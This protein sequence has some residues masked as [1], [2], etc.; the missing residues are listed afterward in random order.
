MKI[1]KRRIRASKW[2]EIGFKLFGSDTKKW[3]YVCFKCGH[4]QNGKKMENSNLPAT[5][6]CVQCCNCLFNLMDRNVCNLNEAPVLINHEIGLVLPSFD[7]NIVNLIKEETINTDTLVLTNKEKTNEIIK[8]K[9][10][11]PPSSMMELYQ[12]LLDYLQPHNMMFS[13]SVIPEINRLE[14]RIKDASQNLPMRDIT[15]D[16]IDFVKKHEGDLIIYSGKEIYKKWTYK[17]NK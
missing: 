15:Q 13:C 9:G 12:K 14:V 1:I 16:C 6:S 17:N 3:E 11:Q 5:L 8:I 10:E 2:R 4:I 7:F